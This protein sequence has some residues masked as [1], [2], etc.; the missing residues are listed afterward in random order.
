[1]LLKRQHNRCAICPQEFNKENRPRID[2]K[3][4][5]VNA[6]GLLCHG[7]NIGLGCFKE[8]PDVLQ[9]AIQYLKETQ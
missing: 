6:R 4:G 5:S 3:H 2:H 7:C 1:L 9:S 8:N